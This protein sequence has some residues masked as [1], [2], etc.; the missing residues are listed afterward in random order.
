MGHHSD[1]EIDAIL[2][3][4]QRMEAKP[5]VVADVP[6]EQAEGGWKREAAYWIGAILTAAA[7]TFVLFGLVIRFI[8][9]DGSSMEPT[10]SDGDHLVMYCLGYTPE[11]GDIVILSDKTGLEIPL[12]KR[13]IAVG[14]QT[15]DISP[16]GKVSVD[17]ETLYEPY[18]VEQMKE[19]GDYDYPLT[20]PEGKV[21]VMGDNR[22]HSTDSRSKKI[23]L[24][25]AD[26]VLGKVVFRLF[27]LD[28]AGPLS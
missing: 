17:G 14:G 18:A 23:G 15:L 20:I 26:Q 2:E 7:I 22:N 4:L 10:L 16:E 13:V 24:V 21:F 3:E 19:I 11:S 8:L 9:V 5:P 27:P 6:Q 25:D 28:E 1:Q 12:V